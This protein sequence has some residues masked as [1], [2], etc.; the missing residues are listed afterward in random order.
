MRL[1]FWF[2]HVSF[3]WNVNNIYGS[4]LSCKHNKCGEDASYG[5]FISLPVQ[6]Y[7]TKVSLNEKQTQTLTETSIKKNQQNRNNL[8]Q[9]HILLHSYGMHLLI[10]PRGY[11]WHNWWLVACLLCEY[12]CNYFSLLFFFWLFLFVIRAM[13]WNM[14]SLHKSFIFV[15]VNFQIWWHYP[16]I[17]LYFLTCQNYIKKNKSVM[18]LPCCGSVMKFQTCLKSFQITFKYLLLKIWGAMSYKSS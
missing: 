16:W 7:R 1:F 9:Y 17:L 15:D 6:Q 4:I 13:L 3:C 18:T 11:H 8:K 12:F 2:C 10:S 14:K 5:D